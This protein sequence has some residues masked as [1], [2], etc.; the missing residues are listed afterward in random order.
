[1]AARLA[2]EFQGVDQW[3]A[4][5]LAET[6]PQALLESSLALARCGNPADRNLPQQMVTALDRC[7]WSQLSPSQR[8]ALLRAYGLI[9]I[10]LAPADES[11]HAMLIDRIDGHFP[12][13]DASLNRELSRLLCFLNAPAIVDRTLSLLE[14]APTQEE[15]IHNVYA[16]RSVIADS[17]LAQQERYFRWFQ[18][19]HTWRGG[20]SLKGFLENIKKEAVDGL[21]DEQ[22]EQL[23]DALTFP[24]NTAEGQDG[25]AGRD[26]VREYSVADVVGMLQAGMRGRSHTAGRRLFSSAQCFKCHRVGDE[27]GATGPDLTAVGHRFG[28]RDLVEAIVEPSKVISDRY[29]ATMF[30][31]EDGRVVTGRVANLNNDQIMVV[32]NML[33]PGDLTSI[34]REEI[35]SFA[36]VP[37]SEMP[38]GLLNTFTQDEILDLMAYL[39]SGGD[40]AHTAFGTP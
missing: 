30:V 40:R 32:T 5:A 34:D 33:A 27:G 37:T 1:Y 6:E 31:L 21:T 36:P 8:L 2:I 35:E 14:V 29:R 3:Q 13:D 16:L 20:H 19:A 24:E 4:R 23:G 11:I 28:H 7:D 9:L 38:A 25:L 15:Q 12:A 22:R 26:L 39:L 17:P 18:Q 10:R